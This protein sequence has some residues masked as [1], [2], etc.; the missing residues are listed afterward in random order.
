[1]VTFHVVGHL[2]FNIMVNDLG[3][4]FVSEHCLCV[5]FTFMLSFLHI[6]KDV[7]Y[8]YSNLVSSPLY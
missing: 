1:M 6:S 8:D 5:M 3:M 2:D 7:L 4:T